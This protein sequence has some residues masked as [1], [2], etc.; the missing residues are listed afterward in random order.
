MLKRTI[1]SLFLATVK[2]NNCRLFSLTTIDNRQQQRY[3]DEHS[4]ELNNQHRPFGKF[5]A[6]SSN[7][8]NRL[9]HPSDKQE[10]ERKPQFNRYNTTR[11][12]SKLSTNKRS[13]EDDDH[14][15]FSEEKDDLT[16]VGTDKKAF[17]SSLITTTSKPTTTTISL[18]KKPETYVR[19]PFS[20]ER[21][22]EIM[23][24]F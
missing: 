8:R 18:D 3:T 13:V 9:Q 7:P 14:D 22:S 20:L 5:H 15:L 11:T 19:P 24:L 12:H 17:S 4:T 1:S 23:S 6:R 16:M 2:V 10:E 21:E